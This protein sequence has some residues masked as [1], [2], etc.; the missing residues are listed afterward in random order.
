MKV[1]LTLNE[2]KD[3]IIRHY[4][5][6][7]VDGEI[8]I[9]IL[10]DKENS[11]KP[12]KTKPTPK[13]PVTVIG[14]NLEVLDIKKEESPKPTII[15]FTDYGVI[16]EQFIS[17]EEKEKQVNKEGLSR[18]T[19]LYRYR[20]AIKIFGFSGVKMIQRGQEVWIVKD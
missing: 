16:I 4:N 7:N 20:K 8:D 15:D 14:K 2:A 6:V 13:E 11:V 19:I 12:K 5:L 18:S 9:E 3:A 10:P 1:T 17:S